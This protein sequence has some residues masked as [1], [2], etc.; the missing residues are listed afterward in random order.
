LLRNMVYLS[1]SCQDLRAWYQHFLS[2]GGVPMCCIM[3]DGIMVGVHD[4]M[5]RQEAKGWEGPG[6]LFL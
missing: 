5:A 1:H 4:H 6:L 3:V 2:S